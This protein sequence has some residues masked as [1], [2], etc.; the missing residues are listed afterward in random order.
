MSTAADKELPDEPGIKHGPFAVMSGASWNVLDSRGVRIAI[1]GGDSNSDW[2]KCGPPI[3]AAIVKALNARIRCESAE[4][5]NA[6]EEFWECE[7]CSAKPGTPVL[8]KGCLHN[9][10]AISELKRLLTLLREEVESAWD[11]L[12]ANWVTHQ[13]L[14]AGRKACEKAEAENARLRN[15]LA[16]MKRKAG[17]P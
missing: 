12:D 7:D 9:R 4:A 16:A 10:A 2:E 11:S 6:R 8:C 3:A 1:C 14:I 17:E 15:E 13:Q 5:D